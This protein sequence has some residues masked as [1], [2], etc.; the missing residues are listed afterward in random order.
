MGQK[1]V[2]LAE[3]QNPENWSG[4]GQGGFYFS[5]QDSR[6]W[7][8]KSIPAMGWTINVGQPA[9]A[10]WLLGFLV[11]LPLAIVLLVLATAPR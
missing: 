11:G 5:K 8:P 10:R 9:G 6:T 3:W 7:V 1:E 2:N 4:P